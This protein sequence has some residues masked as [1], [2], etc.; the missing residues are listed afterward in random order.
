MG[1]YKSATGIDETPS[2]THSTTTNRQALLG[3]VIQAGATED[4]PP[5]AP[6]GLVATAGNDLVELDW[7][8]NNEIDL[9]GYNVYRSMTSGSGY[10]KINITVVDDSNYTDNTVVN[11]T[12]YFY[13][14]TAVDINDNESGYSDEATTIP[15][16]QTCQDVLDGGYRLVSDINGDC[17]VDFL[18]VDKIALYWLD[19]NCASHD[20]CEDADLEPD[21]DVDFVDFSDFAVDWTRCNHP[22]DSNCPANW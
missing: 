7:D 17:Y 18:D 19:T 22:Q 8:D 3:F 15:G 16:Y 21:G 2:V 12:P 10:G 5:A 13:V 11:G 6:T 14:V 9:Y 4:Y 1:G 20:N